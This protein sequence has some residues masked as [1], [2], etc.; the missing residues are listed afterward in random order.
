MSQ[1]G[2]DVR[3]EVGKIIRESWALAGQSP[4]AGRDLVLDYIIYVI[5]LGRSKRRP[6]MLKRYRTN[7]RSKSLN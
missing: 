4:A 2:G 6:L 1:T 5:A 7:A 3:Q